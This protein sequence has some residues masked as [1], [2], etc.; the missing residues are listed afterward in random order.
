MVPSFK[1]DYFIAPTLGYGHVF[2]CAL[3]PAHCALYSYHPDHDLAAGEQSLA[4]GR[5][6]YESVA[7]DQ[8][9]E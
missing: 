8:G 7:V 2:Y 9:L 4:F 6:A 3:C 5:D 1:S